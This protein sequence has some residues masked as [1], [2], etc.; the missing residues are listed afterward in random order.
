ML[1]L[2]AGSTGID[3]HSSRCSHLFGGTSEHHFVQMKPPRWAVKNQERS[4][5]RIVCLSSESSYVVYSLTLL[6]YIYTFLAIRLQK[7]KI[8]TSL[9]LL[10]CCQSWETYASTRTWMPERLSWN[11]SVLGALDTDWQGEAERHRRA[12][13]GRCWTHGGSVLGIRNLSRVSTCTSVLWEQ[14]SIIQNC[15]KWIETNGNIKIKTSKRD[16]VT[17]WRHFILLGKFKLV[18]HGQKLPCSSKLP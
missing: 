6:T 5:N 10:K 11:A 7:L 17:S 3:P 12:K 4:L 15:Q 14:L 1:I 16:Q 8:D 13:Q 18:K 9:L 2:F